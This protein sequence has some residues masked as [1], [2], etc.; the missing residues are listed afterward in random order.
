VPG[1]A[2]VF[3]SVGGQGGA[4]V[5]GIGYATGTATIAGPISMKTPGNRSMS[6]GPYFNNASLG[7]QAVGTNGW[8]D[9]KVMIGDIRTAALI[10]R[11][12]EK[13]ARGGTRYAEVLR[14]HFGVTSP[15]ARLQRPE[16]LG[17]GRT[18]I[19]I[20]PLEQTSE[21]TG[22]ALLG[23]QAGIGT[24]QVYNH[25]FSQSFTEHG[26]IIGLVN[27]RGDLTYQQGI[28]RMWFRRDKYEFYW[29]GLNGLSEQAI[30]NREIFA[31]GSVNDTSVFG[32]QERWSEYK[33][34][35]SR[36]SAAF[37]STFTT[38]LDMWH[39]AENFA[40]RPALNAPFVQSTTP[41]TRVLQAPAFA[42]QAFL[43]DMLFDCRMVRCMPMYSLPGMGARL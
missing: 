13:D 21:T 4:P 24:A 34:K 7:V 32:Y 6:Y 1:G 19:N 2:F 40:V 12:L 17:G 25:G 28:S 23:E 10:Q 37:R 43:C 36:T 31:D 8:P 30:Y 42:G 27:I 26:F 15:D 38:P 39:F 20:H 35:V 16:Y 18:Y 9:I 3:G 41:V 29:P 22:T 5:T 11:M 14:A 33:S